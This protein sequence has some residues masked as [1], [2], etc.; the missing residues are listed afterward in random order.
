ML[1]GRNIIVRSGTSIFII[2]LLLLTSASIGPFAGGEHE[3]TR[4]LSSIYWPMIGRDPGHSNMGDRATRGIMEPVITWS[5]DTGSLGAVAVD[6]S[7]NIEFDGLDPYP[8]FAVVESSETHL[9]VRDGD[10]G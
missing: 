9:R 5:N 8:V 3:K 4:D 6:I 1:H 10:T 7:S 2:A